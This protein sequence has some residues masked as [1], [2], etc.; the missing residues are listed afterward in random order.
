MAAICLALNVLNNVHNSQ[1][2]HWL[3]VPQ[4]TSITTKPLSYTDINF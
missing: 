3:K 4:Q 2:F 1:L